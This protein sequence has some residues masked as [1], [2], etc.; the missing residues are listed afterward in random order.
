MIQAYI[1][2]RERS[3]FG[4]ENKS[5]AIEFEINRWANNKLL[6]ASCVSETSCLETVSFQSSNYLI[7][8]DV[9][10]NLQLYSVSEELSK[11][12]ENHT[13]GKLLNGLIQKYSPKPIVESRQAHPRSISC[14]LNV[15]QKDLNHHQQQA[16]FY[17]ACDGTLSAWRF[18]CSNSHLCAIRSIPA[19]SSTIT[20]IASSPTYNLIAT[21]SFD[22]T[23]KL[24]HPSQ[25]NPA[26]FFQCA[27]SVYS[28]SFFESDPHLIIT[29]EKDKLKIWDMRKHSDFVNAIK[30]QDD[31]TPTASQPNPTNSPSLFSNNTNNRENSFSQDLDSW[32]NFQ[33][34]FGGGWDDD[35][36]FES[37]QQQCE[38]VAM[39]L[40][41]ASNLENQKKKE[42]WDPNSK[43]KK[44]LFSPHT[45]SV[46]LN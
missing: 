3:S 12:Q 36:F 21:S 26:I 41:L 17:A 38:I 35:N 42:I 18:D 28:V 2:S 23:F 11:Q 44:N 46:I 16:N 24:W 4:I 20:A 13:N 32:W 5:R 33:S 19:H 14:L 9:K 25:P 1:R 34:T 6:F 22:C 7:R 39:S 43:M 29:N 45:N 8:G 27:N 37:Q 30:M 10:G 15:Q 31:H 40:T